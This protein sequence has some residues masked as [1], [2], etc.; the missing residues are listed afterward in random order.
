MPSFHF[1]T[2]PRIVCERG[3]ALRLARILQAGG[4]RRAFL[5]TDPGLVAAGLIDAPAAALRA[6]GLHVTVYD[7]V[8][9]DPPEHVVLE[10][11]QAARDDRAD[12]VIGLG[13]GSSLDTAK[14]VPLLAANPQPLADIYG[15]QRARGPRLPL[16]Q[17]PTTAG[18]GSEVT[19]TSVVSTPDHQKRGV[20]SSLLFPDVAVLDAALTA[21]LPPGPTAM[22]G[23]DAMVHAIEAYT[24][25]HKKNPMSDMLAVRAL[26]LLHGHLG[27]AVRQ[28]GDLDSREAML[29][30]SLLAGMAFANAPVAAI[31]AL[32]HPLGSHFHVPHGLAN[33]LVMVPILRFNLP[34]AEAAYAELARALDPG[35][36][37]VADAEAALAFIA[38]MQAHVT[39]SP[40]PQRLRD[41]GVGESDLPVLAEAAMTVDR[42]LM[43]NP[44]DLTREDALAI[45][46]QAF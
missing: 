6:A 14:L 36:R 42:L 44:R 43:N 2:T 4:H 40:I 16:I 27:G 24:T 30:G 46:T 39:A 11:A 33:S 25:R 22:T 35:L 18:T 37:D 19:P 31:H 23:I 28:G 8:Q 34:V 21:A 45:Y 29:L 10:A 9:A 17:V 12:C 1:E 41:V 32:A 13:G 5:V 7:R 26:Q 20:I 38:A 3:A 15:P